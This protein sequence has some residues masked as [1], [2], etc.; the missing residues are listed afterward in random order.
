MFIGSRFL[1]KEFASPGGVM[2][3]QGGIFF[4][5]GGS[6]FGVGSSGQEFNARASR[7]LFI[8]TRGEGGSL[9]P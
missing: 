7:L 3:R 6:G 1:L 5:P 9:V 4:D 8:N 2:S